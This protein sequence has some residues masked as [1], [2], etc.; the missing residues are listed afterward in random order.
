MA[1]DAD[2]AQR[3]MEVLDELRRKHRQTRPIMRAHDWCIDCDERIE[4]ARLKA[5]PYA[6]RCIVCQGDYERISAQYGGG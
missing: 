6:E 1:D 3:D 2:R 4:P 5:M